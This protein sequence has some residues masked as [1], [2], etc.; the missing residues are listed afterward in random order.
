MIKQIFI[1]IFRQLLLHRYCRLEVI[2][3]RWKSLVHAADLAGIMVMRNLF[4]LHL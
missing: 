1:N 3:I 2:K 4:L